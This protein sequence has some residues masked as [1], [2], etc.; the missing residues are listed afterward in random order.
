M[1]LFN[2]FKKKD[3]PPLKCKFADILDLMREYIRIDAPTLNLIIRYMGEEHKMGISSDMEGDEF[4]D[5]RY[6]L[7]D[8]EF[9]TETEYLHEAELYGR[10]LYLLLDEVVEVLKD[11]DL[12]NW[13]NPR[14]NILLEK[15]EIR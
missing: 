9:T 4:V 8:T 1:G 6:H 13:G 11:E 14:G 2:I 3:Y 15:R 7:D 10:Y 12:G 5:I